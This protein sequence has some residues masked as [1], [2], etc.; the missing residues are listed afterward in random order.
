[1][2]CSKLARII[3]ALLLAAVLGGC[4]TVRLAYNNLPELSYW[5][6]DGY[7]DFDDSQSPRV[8]EQLAQLLAWHRRE[9]LPR[10]IDLLQEAEAQASGDVTPEQAC[11]LAD[12]LR[13]RLLAVAER[14]EAPSV[15]M[16][17][18]LSPAQ[19]EH[20]AHKYAKVNAD[21]AQQ[22]L[23]IGSAKQQE[24]RLRQIR[25]RYEDFYGTLDASQRELLRLQ[26]AQSSFD[27]AAQDAERRLHQR[28][29]LALL[30]RVVSGEL[31]PA[32]A[33][34]ALHAY[35]LQFVEAAP[36]AQRERQQ[37]LRQEAC[38]TFA[39]LHNQATPAQ[40]EQARQKL[41]GYEGDLRRLARPDM[42]R[43]SAAAQPGALDAAR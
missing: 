16:A 21:Y 15:E 5:W 32:E 11:A 33:R 19:L 8:R 41:I 7:V 12:A 37:R 31:T 17:A 25:E 20:L 24:K 10:L 4:S 1:M 6:L 35:V 42:S 36:G 18:S 23:S 39:A 2:R 29:T 43:P 28:Q 40:R 13:L 38:A 9:E 30:Q 22:W 34:P 27:P 14:A 26:L 3:G